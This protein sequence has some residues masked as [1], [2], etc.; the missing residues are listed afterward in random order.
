MLHVLGDDADAVA[1]RGRLR[2]RALWHRRACRRE[3]G[4]GGGRNR[5]RRH[6]AGGVS[7]RARLIG[8]RA[9]SGVA[10]AWQLR[11][12]GGR[13]WLPTRAGPGAPGQIKI[14]GRDVH[15]FGA[16]SGGV[17]TRRCVS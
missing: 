6:G 8:G 4:T 3:I 10:V 11:A 13:G 14:C 7:R 15:P 17:P 9:C 16:R 12:R 5:L 2:A 1:G